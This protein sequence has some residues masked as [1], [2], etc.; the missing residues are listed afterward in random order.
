MN[1]V[2]ITNVSEDRMKITYLSNTDGELKIQLFENNDF[3][4]E[5]VL[6]VQKNFIYWTSFGSGWNDKEIHFIS[7]YDVQIVKIDG[8]IKNCPDSYFGDF[9]I[10]KEIVDRTEL[11]DFF[12]KNGSDKSSKWDNGFSK[13][14]NYSKFYYEIFSHFI[15]QDINLFELGLGSNNSNYKYSMGSNGVPCASLMAWFEFFKKAKVY[16]AD[17][18]TDILF[19]TNEYKTFYCD[20]TNEKIIKQMWG[21]KELDKL[22]QIIIDDGVHEFDYN[23]KFLEN[24]YHKIDVGGYYI[25]EDIKTDNLLNWFFY[26][27]KNVQRYE[28]FTFNFIKLECYHNKYDNNLILLKR[29]Y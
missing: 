16:G 26:Y 24:S 21:H 18:D 27:K 1:L 8:T 20:Q 28:N 9:L 2:N 7:D 5:H 29:I 6:D 15:N 22:F 3:I 23:V 12:E 14:H 10:S 19:D 13:G 25:I 4:F 17:I 11:C